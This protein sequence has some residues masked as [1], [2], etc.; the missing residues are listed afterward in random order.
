MSEKPTSSEPIDE[1][2]SALKARFEELEGEIEALGNSVHAQSVETRVKLDQERDS[3]FDEIQR[4]QEEKKE[5]EKN[6]SALEEV[7]KL[8]ADLKR[9]IADQEA[10]NLSL[11][12]L[13]AQVQSRGQN[14]TGPTSGNTNTNNSAPAV[15]PTTAP[16]AP[17]ASP[18]PAP[19]PATP[20]EKKDTTAP[21]EPKKEEP[22]KPAESIEPP[23]PKV[24]RKLGVVETDLA[25]KRA[26]EVAAERM[27][28]NKDELK[29][30]S[31][32]FKKIWTHNWMAEH[33]RAKEVERVRQEMKEA[34]STQGTTD[35]N[36]VVDK[37]IKGAILERFLKDV[38]GMVHETA[39]EWKD[40]L[41]H[42][43]PEQRAAAERGIREAIIAYVSNADTDTAEGNLTE[44]INREYSNVFCN[45]NNK[46][47]FEPL[48]IADNIKEYAREM[49]GQVEH[50]VAI[51]NL[52]LDFELTF[53]KAVT[54]ARTEAAYTWRDKMIE[55]MSRNRH[56]RF[57]NETTVSAAVCIAASIAQAATRW[58]IRASV[59]AFGGGLVAGGAMAS[60][61]E[62]QAVKRDRA[63]HA[64][65]M[66]QGRTFNAENSPRRKEIN[67]TVYNMLPAR[68]A[69]D[70]LRN[71]SDGIENPSGTAVSDQQVI[72]L[73][74]LLG[75]VDSKINLSDRE[76]IDLLSYSDE[77]N[78]EVER[79]ELDIERARA[80]VIA[81]EAYERSGMATRLGSFETYCGT[82]VGTAENVAIKSEGGIEAKDK[83]FNALK[84]RR[85]AG[86][87]VKGAAIAGVAGA[88][89]REAVHMGQDTY[90]HFA[91]T[92]GA[93]IR[94]H[95]WLG[96]L[97]FKDP[98][99]PAETQTIPGF[100]ETHNVTTGGIHY[101]VTNNPSAVMKLPEGFHFIPGSNP[102]EFQ[103]MQGGHFD[104]HGHIV[105]GKMVAD[106]IGFD[107]GTPG[108]PGS[109]HLNQA[110]EE[111]LRRAGL[112]PTSHLDSSRQV[113]HF[114]HSHT[115]NLTPHEYAAEHPQEF[116]RA[117]RIGWAD[118]HTRKPDLNELRLRDPIIGKDG[119]IHISLK[120]MNHHGSTMGHKH[121][122]VPDLVH[123][124]RVELWISASQDSQF[125]PA[126][127]QVGPDGTAVIDPKSA[128]GR[129]FK[130]DAHGHV[131]D[132]PRFTEVAAIMGS[133][134]G[135]KDAIICA[136]DEGKNLHHISTNVIDRGVKEIINNRMI[137]DVDYQEPD[138]GPD[139]P[140]PIPFF[141]PRTPLE[142]TEG[143]KGGLYYYGSND[144]GFLER[145]MSGDRPF[146][147]DSYFEKVIDGKKVWVDKEGNPVKRDKDRENKR[148]A[149]YL[150]K[151]NKSYSKELED[152]EKNIGPMNEKCR[153][154]INIPARFEA[155]N[156]PNLLDQYVKQ[157]DGSGKEIDK[158]LFEINII[159]N[160]KEGEVADNSVKVLSE[161]KKKNPGYHVNVVD[162]TFPQEKANVGMARKYITDLTLRRSINRNKSDG[163]LYIE[164]EDA[165]LFSID[166]RTVWKLIKDF[167][168]EPHLDVLRG[169]QDRQPEVLQKN[170]LL[171][172]DQRM[173]DVQEMLLRKV[174]YRPENTK[175]NSFVW[176]R[177]ISGGW[178]TAYTAEAY[179][180]IGGYV[181]DL[182]GED[183][184][185]GQKISLLRGAKN[186]ESGEL[187]I[188]TM[189]SK[190]SGLRSSSSPRRFI[191]TMNKNIGSYDDFENQD[192]KHK[193]LDELLE[194]S[195]EFAVATKEKKPEYQR[196]INGMVGFVKSQIIEK[197]VGT[198]I[199]RTMWAM[200]LK[201][202]EG[203]YT[204]NPDNS[205][206]LTDKG[207]EQ[208][209]SLMKNYK[210]KKKYKLGYRRQNAPASVK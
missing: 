195:K 96:T 176:N 118:N 182:I 97:L 142:R 188:N 90:G 76:K 191:D 158:D 127:I 171:F 164:S 145:E 18:S 115:K 154:A 46:K 185:I 24:K 3:L 181:S 103:I 139:L 163:P 87:F 152:F 107:N 63:E 111:A 168:A 196:V 31:G 184:K 85:V 126:H 57:I 110:S 112:N 51:A 69:I 47:G 167:D 172:F 178:N 66:A 151:Q 99:T 123:K 7:N 89:F 80:R 140:M 71:I 124:G 161:W 67:E 189:T 134:N 34:G 101:E 113:S 132:R 5:S 117:H 100:S 119:K 14:Q 162:I 160:H 45:S 92:P 146:D 169:V 106:H 41:D 155:K 16:S 2:I 23:K 35:T 56:G 21:P 148:I 93:G 183:M 30:V 98:N 6:G 73:I 95:S 175:G 198:T 104:A 165:D 136:T 108:H 192:L 25:E 1:K 116:Q 197:Q 109:Y 59:G 39:G 52:D 179:A 170:E 114:D 75:S 209:I 199:N 37:K 128:V 190:T 62:A 177:V 64:R 153:V 102:N 77:Q 86:A 61:R 122:D 53:G 11:K 94:P 130:F 202:K 125:T 149:E 13:I 29:G 91:H 157:T 156:L 22:P 17:T 137:T 174:A 50:G 193:T 4:L 10:L 187:I 15:P 194:G 36:A 159:V 206:T 83:N 207:M 166:K 201:E 180:Q 38:P 173:R 129:L 74:G 49:K 135:V 105:G 143:K 9:Q 8:N 12:D 200:G 27:T 43:N 88:V 147:P 82:V 54:G 205:V 20:P 26:R 138:L 141:I 58:S 81:K 33:Y 204:L 44:A 72:D 48:N 210:D 78:V 203:H 133:H 65:A 121:L 144:K 131:I 79:T 55:K 68:T 40:D 208:I 150:A 120:G 42:L 28:R 19:V 70:N 186:G 84:R 60:L 32:F